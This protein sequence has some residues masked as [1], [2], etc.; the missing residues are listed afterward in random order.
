MPLPLS[1][2]SAA[3]FCLI[4]LASTAAMDVQTGPKGVGEA[5]EQTVRLGQR[6]TYGRASIRPLRVVGDSRCPVGAQ[7][8]WAGTVQ[9]LVEMTDRGN[10]RRAVIGMDQSL[11]LR[12]GL[13]VTLALAC[14]APRLGARVMAD[15]Y[16]FTFLRG[17]TAEPRPFDA[18]CPRVER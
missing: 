4:W 8:V 12:A 7:C 15:Q 14:P 17:T 16:R 2:K 13:W 11:Q 18:V 1:N 3:A 9:V 10:S 6:A 5:E